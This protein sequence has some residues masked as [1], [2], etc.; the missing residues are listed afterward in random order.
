MIYEVQEMNEINVVQTQQGIW[1]DEGL[2]QRAGLGRRLQLVVSTGEIRIH[3]APEVTEAPS[4][5]L[6]WDVFRS[7]GDD[8]QPGRLPDS[9]TGHDRYLYPQKR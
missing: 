1:I 4:L 5:E 8:A 3:A 6:G 2:L 9:A 7:L